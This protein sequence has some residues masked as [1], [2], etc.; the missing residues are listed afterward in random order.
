MKVEV[1]YHSP[2]GEVAM[3]MF[4]QLSNVGYLLRFASAHGGVN[5][6]NLRWLEPWTIQA[7]K[8]TKH[9]NKLF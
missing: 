7:N 1:H 6:H 8:A 2:M 3:H 9:P 4:L 5:Q